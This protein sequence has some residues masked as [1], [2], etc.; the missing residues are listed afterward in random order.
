MQIYYSD[1]DSLQHIAGLLG[2]DAILP[3][4]ETPVLD[5]VKAAAKAAAKAP[6]GQSEDIENGMPDWRAAE[7]AMYALG[8][9][10]R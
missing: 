10:Y 8:V 6:R 5:Y 4:L 9:L 7:A 1:M 2:I 3:Q